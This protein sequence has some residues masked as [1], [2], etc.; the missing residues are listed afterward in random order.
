MK[1]FILDFDYLPQGLF[2]YLI[3]LFALVADEIFEFR[4]IEEFLG[5][6][7]SQKLIAQIRIQ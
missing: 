2:C 1:E 5:F 4:F 6:L 7:F 3:D